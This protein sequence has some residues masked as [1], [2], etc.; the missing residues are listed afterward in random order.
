MAPSDNAEACDV[1]LTQCPMENANIN[2]DTDSG[3]CLCFSF[4]Y[5]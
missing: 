1:N 5:F 2:Y 4:Q 3:M